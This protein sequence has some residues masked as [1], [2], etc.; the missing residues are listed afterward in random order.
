MIDRPKEPPKLDEEEDDEFGNAFPNERPTTPVGD[1]APEATPEE[2]PTVSPPF[3]V[4][5]YA[6][7]SDSKMRTQKSSSPAIVE[8]ASTKP[9]PALAFEP[10]KPPPA[11]DLDLAD[12]LP[13]VQRP[14]GPQITLTDEDET[15]EAR[16][17]SVLMRSDPPPTRKGSKPAKAEIIPPED[18]PPTQAYPAEYEKDPFAHLSTGAGANDEQD[19]LGDMRDRFSLGDYTG[20]LE[21][22]ESILAQDSTNADASR[23]ADEC[24]VKLIQMYTARIGPLDRVPMVVVAR[25]Q[26][27]WLSIDHRAGFLLSHVDGVSSL[28]MILDVSGMP[29]LDALKILTELQQQRVIS[30]R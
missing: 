5:E 17:R 3:D 16:L 15:E 21:V 22:A 1:A 8:P 9:P 6:K 2:R 23:I 12:E 29:L 30:F 13:P 10:A 7:H 27:R 14:R 18:G 20:A 26:L 24:R 25:E 11:L 19:R 4:E 28:E